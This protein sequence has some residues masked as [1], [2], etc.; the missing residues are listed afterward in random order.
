MTHEMP[1]G[2]TSDAYDDDDI[3]WADPQIRKDYEAALGRLILAHNDVD[4]FLTMLIECVLKDLGDQKEL[5]KL[6]QGLFARRLDNLRMLHGIRPELRLEG[7]DFDEL[8]ELN[9]LRNIVAHGHFEQNPFQG[10]YELISNNKTH[11]DFS[12]ERLDEITKR[13][14]AVGDQIKPQV[15]FWDM[16]IHLPEDATP[17]NPDDPRL[18]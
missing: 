8:E 6:T 17:V 5:E 18:A 11:K 14:D 10:D 1:L 3:A 12:V 15:Y 4:R 7:I 13:I 2:D 9:R 16:I